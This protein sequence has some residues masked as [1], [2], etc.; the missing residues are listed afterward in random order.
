MRTKILIAFLMIF[1]IGFINFGGTTLQG[2]VYGNS[3]LLDVSP[4]QNQ[5]LLSQPSLN[6]SLGVAFTPLEPNPETLIIEPTFLPVPE[7]D[8][9]FFLQEVM[10]KKYA[11]IIF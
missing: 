1:L 3:S 8:V 10:K 4:Q 11:Q 7:L 9:L 5:S 6:I 2:V